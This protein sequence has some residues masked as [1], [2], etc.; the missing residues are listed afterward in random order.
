MLYCRIVPNG[1]SKAMQRLIEVRVTSLRKSIIVA[2]F[3]IWM[4]TMIVVCEM[5]MVCMCVCDPE[6]RAGPSL[7]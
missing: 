2:V 1:Q 5:R 6:K 4:M 3:L 7:T